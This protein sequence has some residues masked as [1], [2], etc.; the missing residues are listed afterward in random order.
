LVK[1]RPILKGFALALLFGGIMTI[2][3]S[4][5]LIMIESNYAYGTLTG[6]VLLIFGFVLAGLE[7]T[8]V[9][10]LFRIEQGSDNQVRNWVMLSML[11]RLLLVYTAFQA[12]RSPAK[13]FVTIL[14]ILNVIALALEGVL[15]LLVY[16]WKKEFLPSA[17]EVKATMRRMGK[18]T[19]KTVSECPNCHEIVEKGW[20]LCPQCGTALPRLCANC[21]KPLTERTDKCMNC[22]A[23]IERQESIRS[24]IKTLIALS[25]EDARPEARSVRYARLA[26][27]YLK[28]GETD[29]SLE[30]YRKAIHFS[31]F[32]RKRANFL[33]KMANVLHNAGRDREATEVLDA[34]LQL[35]PEDV[36]GATLVKGQINAD[37]TAKRAREALAAGDEEKALA[38]A[39]EAVR[40]DPSDYH[41]AL[42]IKSTI[43]TGRAKKLLAASGS[44][45]DALKLLDEAVRLDPKGL[46]PATAARDKLAPKD[47]KRLEKAKKKEM[48]AMLRAAAKK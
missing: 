13:E 42:L 33:V 29:L 28:N 30:T 9:F 11:F 43:L 47:M 10:P 15:L 14:L 24:S 23:I 44:T 8:T 46:G 1:G 35:D 12:L 26:E 32:D 27:A 34:A 45:E 38:L 3:S 40:I 19:V 39:D 2:I 18:A 25:E 36:A 21:G 31:E 48:K 7:L 20:V 16:V 22:G 6:I 37:A 4:F 41:G 5:F 17:E